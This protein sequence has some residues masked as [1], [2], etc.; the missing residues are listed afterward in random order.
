MAR[1]AGRGDASIWGSRSPNDMSLPAVTWAIVA[2]P[3]KKRKSA[4][5]PFEQLDYL[6]TPSSDVA[7][8]ARYF[9]DVL[10]GKLAFAIE[11]VGTRVAKIEL[12]AGPPHVLLTD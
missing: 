10:G 5:H 12:T 3:A 7:A 6:Y 8:D 1:A 4:G 2:A 11:S 9:T